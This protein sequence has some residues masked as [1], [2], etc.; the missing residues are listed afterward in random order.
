LAVNRVGTLYGVGVGPGDP[1]LLTLKALRVIQQVPVVFVPIP[2]AGAA[3]FAGSIVEP[4][5]D[6]SRQRLEKLVFAM[7]DDAP[8]ME[9]QWVQNARTI[10][11]WLAEGQDAAFAT[12]GDPMLYSTFGHIRQALGNVLPDAAVVA[13]PGVSSVHAAAA[14]A[15]APLADRD[16]RVAILP[17]MYEGD[18]LRSTLAAFDTVVLLKLSGA[19]DR[20]LDDL[21]ELDLVDRAVVVSRCGWPEERIVRDVR[22]LRGQRI[23]YFS[24]MIVRGKG[25]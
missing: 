24:T 21:E 2:R 1:E 23:D 22:S 8:T 15:L 14:A 25:L 19:I 4:Y 18:E 20:V 10:G 9:G 17:A 6:P 5:L 16:E 7:R 11:A 3:S 13:I 12:E